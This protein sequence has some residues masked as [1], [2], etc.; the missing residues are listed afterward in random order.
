MNHVYLRG[1]GHVKPRARRPSLLAMPTA[2]INPVLADRR[3]SP[4]PPRT[5]TPC[6]PTVAPRH[7]RRAHQPRV[8]RPSLLADRRSSRAQ[9]RV[10]RSKRL[11]KHPSSISKPHVRKR[12][13]RL[14][15]EDKQQFMAQRA[16]RPSAA[17]SS[18]PRPPPR[19]RH[20]ASHHNNCFDGPFHFEGQKDEPRTAFCF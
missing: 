10:G 12:D 16:R 7:A 17:L 5:S 20:K 3:S 2:H 15:P 8:R 11:V 14:T 9:D 13:T 19:A 6:S 18:T 1:R 4:C